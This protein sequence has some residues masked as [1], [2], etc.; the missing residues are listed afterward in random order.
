[1]TNERILESYS[2]GQWLRGSQ[3][4]ALLRD[5]STG[6][7]V[8]TI[9]ATG[10]NTSD[11]HSY[12]CEHGAPALKAMSFHQRAL[13]L[14]ALG[15][16]LM[17]NKELFY[18]QSIA[19][20]A[21]RADSW[22]D[23][24]GGIGTLLTYASRGRRELPNTRLLLDGNPEQLSKDD[25]FSA[26]HILMP[27]DGVAIHINAFN[28]PCWGM[29][30]KLAPTL[31]AGMPAIIKPASQ[32]AYLTELMF[33]HIVSSNI[34]PEGA[35]QL[36]CGSVGDLLDRVGAQDVI[37]F[38][39]SA[40]TGQTLRSHSQRI[41]EATRFNMEADSLNACVLGA[42]AHP[43]TPEFDLFV[44]EVK[45]EMTSKAGQ[46]CTAIR[47]VFAPAEHMEAVLDALQQSL[48]AVHTGNP[49]DKSVCMGPLASMTQRDELQQAIDLLTQDAQ[50][51]Y[52]GS[53]Q[54]DQISVDDSSYTHGAFVYPTL[55]YCDA[56]DQAKHVH[57]IEAFGPVCTV[58]P[59]NDNDHAVALCRK[60]GGSL[61]A[62]VF[63]YDNSIASEL[64][65]GL[66]PWHGRVLVG[67][68]EN[69]KSSTGHGSPLPM[70]NHGGPGRAG[71]GAELG[72]MR[73]IKHYMQRCAVQ[74]TP[75][76]LTAIAGQW[77]RGTSLRI[78]TT[79]PF[80]KNLQQLEIGDNIVTQSRSITLEDIEHFAHFTGDTFYA[81]MD[82]KAACENPFF[83]ARVAHGYLIVSLAA[84]LFVDPL[85]G[86]VLANYGV[87]NLRF[88]APVYPD[89]TIQVYLVCKQINPRESENYGEVRWDCTIINQHRAVV[90]Q[91][92]ALTLV[93]K[94]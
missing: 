7:A 2:C 40:A 90:A 1:M 30:E 44:R 23:I 28:F 61:V 89:D 41:A 75:S 50:I 8:A 25:S 69:E 16:S 77:M 71:G 26:Q 76:Q 54:S 15:Q 19:T 81:H 56:P 85:P 27:L 4:G 22:I 32:T 46:K 21:T 86:P 84:G 64:V 45:Q 93:A 43:G 52:D 63:T 67:N 35:I 3:N 62:S 80:R 24:E 68:R 79:H 36:I 20:G 59:Y 91:Y 5:A 49:R 78:D 94:S 53:S 66:A 57:C 33:R 88:M 42:D 58:M 11:M 92:D 10:L 29:L 17:S 60:G 14:K 47:R 12:A 6:E 48:S 13:M 65:L 83:D 82:D 18:A 39:G 55:L 9:D 37:T 74:A 34:L 87:D 73:A 70:L 72:G 31:L 51:V 38:T